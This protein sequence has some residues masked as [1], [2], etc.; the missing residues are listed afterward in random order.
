MR[1][2]TAILAAILALSS[3][4]T[5]DAQEDVPSAPRSVD[6]GVMRTAPTE[7]I[8]A[9]V[10]AGLYVPVRIDEL[11]DRLRA[12]EPEPGTNTPAIRRATWSATLKQTSL[13]NGSLT[14]QLED[15]GSDGTV[16]LGQCNLLSLTFQNEGT[17]IPVAARP[18][19]RLALLMSPTSSTDVTGTW[20]QHGT[21]GR[22][23][24]E[25]DLEVPPAAVTDLR[26]TTAADV[27]LR[28]RIPRRSLRPNPKAKRQSGASTCWKARSHR[29][30]AHRN[31]LR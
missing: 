21:S 4:N 15:A 16:T 23:G 7:E 3:T 30:S 29:S 9:A 24:V 2:A 26:I 31:N 18:D 28:S 11:E 19:G 1:Q 25:F 10:D 12:R 17:D 27:T 22:F 6:A 14:M 5:T 20:S 13:V 8:L